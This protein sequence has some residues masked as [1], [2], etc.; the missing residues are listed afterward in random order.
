VADV[1]RHL[2]RV[3]S[4]DE[5]GDT[6]QVEEVLVV[7]PTTPSHHLVVH[8]RDVCRGATKGSEAEATEETN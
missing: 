4:R 2:C 1:H 8:H 3:R 7:D 5:V 6:D